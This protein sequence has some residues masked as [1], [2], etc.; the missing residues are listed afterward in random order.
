MPVVDKEHRL[1]GIIT[2]DDIMDIIKK[3]ATEDMEKMAGLE[4]AEKPYF[5]T[6]AIELAKNRIV[7]L[8]LLMVSSMITGSILEN[9]EAAFAAIPLLVTFI[10]MLT[11][12][13]GNCG[14]QSST[15][16]IRG[17]SLGEIHPK[18]ILKVLWKEL[19]VSILVGIALSAVNFARIL[20]FNPGQ[21][22]V[23]I[24]VSLA[25]I[26][27]VI[28]AKIVGCALPIG[29]KILKLDPAIMAAPLITTIVDALSLVLYFSI[30]GQ[31]LSI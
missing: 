21:T 22:G 3:E 29:A 27:T 25:V 10:P 8:L 5:K 19:R 26:L 31:L 30:A 24:V 1:V 16:I 17:M 9:Y 11:G 13:G 15:I 4:P 14:S 6:S 12:T 2:V 18:D 7:W 28:L 20:I 23:A